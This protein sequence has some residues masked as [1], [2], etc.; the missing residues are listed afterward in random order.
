MTYAETY[1]GSE[2]LVLNALQQKR[3]EL[4]DLHKQ[5]VEIKNVMPTPF[6]NLDEFYK[7]RL[8]RL[9]SKQHET[10]RHIIRLHKELKSLAHRETVDVDKVKQGN[11]IRDFISQTVELKKRG[12]VMV[13]LCPFHQESNPSFTVY[14]DSYYCFGCQATG[15]IITFV[16]ETNN[17][18]FKEAIKT[19]C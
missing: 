8:K 10:K 7:L 11:D 14:K 2:E 18:Q 15:D 5:V 9:E 6:T 4:E 16:M 12:N 13:G 17:L 19:L 1:G 3:D